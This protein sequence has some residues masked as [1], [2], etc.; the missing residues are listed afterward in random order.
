[1]EDEDEE[2]K[3]QTEE[4]P[5]QED[6]VEEDEDGHH[7]GD[8]TLA[9]QILCGHS[10]AYRHNTTQYNTIQA[11]TIEQNEGREQTNYFHDTGNERRQ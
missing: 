8:L 7:D 4:Y 1:M 2:K 6:E 5:H 3:Q 9:L 10:P 11:R